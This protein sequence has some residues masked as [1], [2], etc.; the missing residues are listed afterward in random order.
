MV[1]SGNSLYFVIKKEKPEEVPKVFEEAA[2]KLYEVKPGLSQTRPHKTQNPKMYFYLISQT[3]SNKPF[4]FYICVLSFWNIR[5]PS[6]GARYSEGPDL[7]V[8]ECLLTP[9]GCMPNWMPL[10]EQMWAPRL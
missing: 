9:A 5:A 10:S 6:S 2:T 3:V 4:F 1:V 7:T 8:V